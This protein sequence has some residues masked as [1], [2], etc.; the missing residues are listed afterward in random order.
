[1]SKPPTLSTALTVVQRG[2]GSKSAHDL[3]PRPPH[4]FCQPGMLTRPARDVE[5]SRVVDAVEHGMRLT[6]RVQLR[7]CTAACARQWVCPAGRQRLA[8]VPCTHP[9][10]RR[11]RCGCLSV[12]CS[13]TTACHRSLVCLR[14][15][16][17]NEF[18]LLSLSCSDY[19]SLP[20]VGIQIK[21][22]L[23]DENVALSLPSQVS[24]GCLSVDQPA[25][26]G[27][28]RST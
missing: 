23:K 8:C 22:R 28:P 19:L 15:Q 7:R 26:Q 16:G 6:V 24:K 5:P 20:S 12:L 13:F 18:S 1:M 11:R 21:N 17:Y 10:R 9:S 2:L 27:G 25:T 3:D 4:R 14:L